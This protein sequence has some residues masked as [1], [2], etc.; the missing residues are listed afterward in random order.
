MRT[1]RKAGI[2]GLLSRL[3]GVKQTGPGKWKALCPAHN[4]TRPSLYVTEKPDGTVLVCCISQRCAAADVM[5]AV[6]LSLRDLYPERPADHRR[7][8]ER[9]R[10][11]A[12]EILS[13]IVTELHVVLAIASD[14]F[15]GFDID[16]AGYARL[17]ATVERIQAAARIGGAHA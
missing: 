3:E 13:A 12:T 16:E 9:P 8:G 4:D 17:H 10:I 15:I 5:A 6:D 11:P 14:M 1:D 2:S 7:K